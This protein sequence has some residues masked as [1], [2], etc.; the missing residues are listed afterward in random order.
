MHDISLRTG[1]MSNPGGAS[2]LLGIQ[3][4]MDSLC[5]GATLGEVEERVGRELGVIRVSLGLA[6][7][8]GDV[9]GVIQLLKGFGYERR[10]MDGI[11]GRRHGSRRR[12]DFGWSL[13]GQ[14]LTFLLLSF[15]SLLSLL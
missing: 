1:C 14:L 7:D 11:H 4:T 8:W 2:A 3:Q 10:R 12:C 6:S 15:F 5:D 9:W 13:L